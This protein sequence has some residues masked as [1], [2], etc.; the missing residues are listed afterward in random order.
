M[1]LPLIEAQ[2][3]GVLNSA[4]QKDLNE[5]L[6]KAV[7]DNDFLE[8][9]NLLAAGANAQFQNNFESTP[10]H[11][12]RSDEIAKQLLEAGA[13][14]HVKNWA[15]DTPLHRVGLATGGVAQQLIDH[16]ADINVKNFSGHTPLLSAAQWVNH[17][18]IKVL[19]AHGA[20]MTVV[21]PRHGFNISQLARVKWRSLM[22]GGLND[23]ILQKIDK[24]YEKYTALH[25]SPASIA[26]R[27]TLFGRNVMDRFDDYLEKND[28][29]LLAEY[30]GVDKSEEIPPRV[31]QRAKNMFKREGDHEIE[32]QEPILDED[33]NQKTDENG[34]P[35]IQTVRKFVRGTGEPVIM[36]QL[37]RDYAAHLA[38]QNAAK[39][40]E[41]P[42]EMSE[43]VR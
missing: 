25:N 29:T 26:E 16:G 19:A 13:D 4:E 14:V 40:A 35:Q 24:I 15:G 3:G 43:E 6:F 31:I 2:V 23:P 22:G 28:P 17:D 20:D 9:K 38:A 33:G 34:V 27:R 1:V 11:V 5:K 18:A 36:P 42:K 10:L 8:V 7:V 32:T 37:R 39:T 12:A 41:A 30:L 21:D